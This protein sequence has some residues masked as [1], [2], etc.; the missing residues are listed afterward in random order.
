MSLP[1]A[2]L[3][4][5]LHFC[6]IYSA[7]MGDYFVHLFSMLNMFYLIYYLLIYSIDF[8]GTTLNIFD[9]LFDYIYTNTSLWY[10]N[11]T[12]IYYI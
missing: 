12:R 2:Y 5:F 11:V 7:Y 9:C 4:L 10:L 3:R 6:L 1:C 8:N